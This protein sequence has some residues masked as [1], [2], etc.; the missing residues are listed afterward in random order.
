MLS[1]TSKRHILWMGCGI[2]SVGLLSASSFGG[3]VTYS[4]ES[5]SAMA[6]IFG[7]GHAVPPDPG[8]GSGGILPPEF[9]LPSGPLVLTFT[10]V[11]GTISLNDGFLGEFND[12]DDSGSSSNYGFPTRD[13]GPVGGISG[14]NAVGTGY[15]VGVFENSSEPQNPAPATLDFTTIGK[16]F[17]SLSPL[18]NQT[19]FVGD[20]LTGDET[21]VVQ[22]F[23]VPA[24][25]TRLFL[26]IAD[27]DGEFPISQTGDFSDNSGTFTASFQ[28]SSTSVP[29]PTSVALLAAGCG[30]LLS[31]R[32]QSR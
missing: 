20:G 3:V 32:R 5:V 1:K 18:L 11:T 4:D 15:I 9:N 19:F 14:I 28:V 22:Q 13:V 27:S 23:N 24:G 16:N 12:P 10:S 30:G 21:G 7:A 2:L 8:G 26:G 6:N 25:A 17:T 29:E 31:R